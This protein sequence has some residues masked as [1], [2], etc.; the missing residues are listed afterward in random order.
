M[1]F[2]YTKSG[3]LAKRLYFGAVLLFEGLYYTF[4][5]RVLADGG[6]FV[7]NELPTISQDVSLVLTPNA[8]KAGKLYSAVPND[9]TGDFTVDRN[10]TAT[11][12]GQDGLIKT[13]LA[14]VQRVDWSTGVPVILRE[15]QSTNLFTYSEDFSNADWDKS[16]LS[17]VTDSFNAPDGSLTADKIIEDTTNNKHE[18]RQG[19]GITIGN[20]YNITGYF[21]NNGVTGIY[22]NYSGL[23][24]ASFDFDLGTVAINYPDNAF[25]TNH[26]GTIENFNNGWYRCSVSFDCI[27]TIQ[28]NIRFSLLKTSSY[29]LTYLG[30][31]VSSLYAWGFQVEEGTEASSYIPTAGV[32]ETRLGDVIGDAGDVNTFNSEEGVLFVEMAALVDNSGARGITIYDSIDNS[33]FL[34]IR[35]D[36]TTNRVLSQ[37]FVGG[38]GQVIINY[39]ETDITLFNKIALRYKANNFSL[40]SNGVKRAENTNGIVPPINSFDTLGLDKSLVNSGIFYGKIKQIKVFKTALTDQ[41]LIAL[42]TP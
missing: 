1:G 18:V 21:K 41:Q 7:E 26:I 30:D 15:P 37:I 35:Y 14:N 42:T 27:Q 3:K 38:V 12:I 10:S 6:T 39:I 13:A 20:S 31:G 29:T 34:Y 28:G 19:V 32:T 22:F 11:Y 24:L 8:Y 9:G 16:N 25:T 36:P 17:V 33:N 23:S 2:I 40:W 5:N 4:K